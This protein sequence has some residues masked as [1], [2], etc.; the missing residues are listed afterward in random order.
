M[1]A[2]LCAY[3][4]TAGPHHSL[5]AHCA[6]LQFA[7]ACQHVP[8]SSIRVCGEH[9]RA[10]KRSKVSKKMLWSMEGWIRLPGSW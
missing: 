9:R 7:T 8:A 10:I 5:H 4:L 3:D 1:Q 6:H 2:G